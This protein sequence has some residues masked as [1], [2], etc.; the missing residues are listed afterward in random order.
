M[1]KVL[2]TIIEKIKAVFVIDDFENIDGMSFD[3]LKEILK[4]DYFLERC[5]FILISKIVKPGM[6]CITSPKLT[7]EN[8]VDLTIAPFTKSQVEILVKQYSDLEIGD[9]FV[10]LALNISGGNP[11]IVEQ[12]VLLYKDIRR[13][14]LKHITYKSLETILDA[15]L[16]ILKQEDLPSY[17]MLVA[18]SVLGSKFY[19]AMLEHFDNNSE[20]EFERIIE[21]LVQRG[22]INQINNLSFEFKS[23]EIWKN[24]VSVVKNDDCFYEILNILYE[25][26]SIY[27]QSSIALIPTSILRYLHQHA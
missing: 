27:K 19:P 14:G 10:N 13:N 17:R 22:Y 20:K 23:N 1:K 6:G 11:S 8:Y 25:T 5:K 15:R 18:M 26:L 3:F 16:G 12:M 24:I 4:D 21:N 9:D 2:L 7:E